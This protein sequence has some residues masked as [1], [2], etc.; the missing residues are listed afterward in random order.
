MMVMVVGFWLQ[1]SG[2][3]LRVPLAQASGFGYRWLLAS[4]FGYRWLLASRFGL[5]VR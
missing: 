3:G 4:G 1:A 5:R 2:F